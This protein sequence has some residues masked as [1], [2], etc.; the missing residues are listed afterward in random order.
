MRGGSAG[1]STYGIAGEG[2]SDGLDMP[3]VCEGRMN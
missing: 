2:V 3:G 1:L